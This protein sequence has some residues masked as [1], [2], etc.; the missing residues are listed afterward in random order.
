M[1]FL[2]FV[3]LC[4]VF[5]LCFSSPTVTWGA[6]GSRSSVAE[7]L[8]GEARTAYRLGIVLYDDGDWEGALGKFEQAYRLSSDPRLLWN[9]AV[10]EKNRR[11]YTRAFTLVNDYLSHPSTKLPAREQREVKRFRDTVENLT[12]FVSIPVKED[13]AT[14][15][16]DGQEVGVT[17]LPQ[18]IRL[19]AG[20]HDLVIR[21]P[22]FVEHKSEISTATPLPGPVALLRDEGRL[23]VK[24]NPDHAAI[25]INGKHAGHGQFEGNQPTGPAFL[26]ISAPGMRTYQDE[27]LI[28][29]GD[30]RTVDVTLESASSRRIWAWVGAGAVA[31]GAAAIATYFIT[32]PTIERPPVQRGSWDTVT[33][34]K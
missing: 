4:I 14:V 23:V 17:P 5:A 34:G 20:K 8:Q 18:A 15:I 22:G 28:R 33:L 32:N 19:D 16:V 27:I 13:G 7:S 26:K 10:C 25:A 29:Q 11:R 9:M 6:E 3:P 2:S 21:K 1:K 12:A 31:L 30:Q 24:V